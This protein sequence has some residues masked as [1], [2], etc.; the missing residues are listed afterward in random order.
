MYY[1]I[2]EATA[3]RANDMN[4]MRDYKPGSATAAYRAEVDAAAELV[5]QQKQTVSAFYH[6]KLD[7][8]L[9]RYARRLAEYYNA[10]Y[11]NEAACPS[12][13][14]SGGSNFPVRKKEKQNSRRE[15]LLQE[16]KDIQGILDKIRSIGTGAIDFA[17]PH[18]RE[19]LVERLESAK[20]LYESKKQAN[21]YYRK[22]KTLDGCPGITPKDREWLTRPGVFARGDGSPLT[23][24]GV[25][26]P[27]YDLQSDNAKI[28][29]YAARLEEYDKLQA[30][31][32]AD[33][34]A[35]FDGGRIVRNVEQ[36]RLQIFFDEIPDEDTRAALKSHGFHWSRR[37]EAWQRQL[38]RNA[39]YD[40]KKILGITDTKP[41]TAAD[42]GDAAQ[43]AAPLATPS[44]EDKADEIQAAREITAEEAAEV[45]EFPQYAIPGA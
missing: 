16:W 45:D 36:N 10:Y 39:I 19:M 17:D 8:L 14:V 41:A 5:E 43:D 29:K 31:R 7:G 12:I 33:N 30:Q 34:D 23:L 15:T 38:T 18:A 13:L 6:D 25:P 42:Q 4:S 40:A 24:Y 22:H 26:F 1:P 3:R 9:D 20:A 21:A 44:A 28:K 27:A 11:R 35:E 32:D 2:D 37:N